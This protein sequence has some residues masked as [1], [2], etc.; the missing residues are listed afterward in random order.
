MRIGA[1]NLTVKNYQDLLKIPI[2]GIVLVSIVLFSVQSS[3]AYTVNYEK[4][5]AR[6]INSPIVCI[7]EPDYQNSEILSESF[8]NR[9]MD[10][11]RI[12]INEW[13]VQL[14]I[15]ERGRD[16]SMWEI[17]QIPITL[18]E[19]K[20]FDYDKCSV[21][22]KFKEKPESKDEYY[23]LLGKTSY[24]LG[25]TGRSDTSIYY[26]A[27]ELCK[28]EDSKWIYFDPCYE[29][30]PRLMQ[31]LQSVVKHEFGHALGLGHYVAD[32][33]DVNVAWARGN[34]PSPSI[35]AVFTHQNINKNFITPQDVS[36]VRSIYGETGFLPKQS[37]EKIF[38]YFQP[39]SF[40]YG[41]PKGEFI[42]ASVDGLISK[43]KYVSGVPVEITMKDPNNIITIKKVIPNSDG[44]FSY[45]TIISEQT[46]T[47]DYRVSAKF[48]DVKSSEVAFHISSNMENKQSKIP[49]W[50]KNSVK[51]W[52]EDKISDLDLVLGIQH[53]IREGILNPPN[54]EDQKS[55]KNNGVIGVKI[56]KFIKQ[57]SIW[58][59]EGI[60]S[61]DEFIAGI[62]F[63]IK[64]GY[65]VI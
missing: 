23:K 21:F 5:D 17:N 28:T 48:R 61:D 60:I 30:Y 31:Q 34:V 10:E 36:A 14:Q 37:E 42:V 59:T 16:K 41:L 63:M 27:I 51:W 64:K 47:G 53:L 11:T 32:A 18:E 24:E 38:E 12:S 50:I 19:Q 49:Q 56:P 25:S 1:K 43:S 55:F 22:I 52:A 40:V 15:S 8:A 4:W 2:I 62:Q 44:I 65:I 58:W 39:S 26:A 3:F 35:M 7:F 6:I 54:S 45:Q 57:T 13:M 29:N 9:L 46:V 20:E 33:L